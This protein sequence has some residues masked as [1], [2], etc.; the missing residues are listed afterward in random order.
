MAAGQ[1]F[2][3]FTTGEVLTAADVNGYLMQ[4]VGVFASST[5]RDAEITSPQEGQFAYLKDTNVTTYYTGSAWANLDTT[6]M[7]NPMTTTGDTIYSSS[8]STPARLGIGSTGQVLT[9]ASGVPSWATPASGGGMTLISTATPSGATGVTFSSIPASYKQLVVVWQG[10]TFS[11]GDTS[12]F[13]R[14]NGDTG[15]VYQSLGSRLNGTTP[16][17]MGPGTNDSFQQVIFYANSG[18]A[19]YNASGT[20]TV[21]RADVAQ[22]H[23]CVWQNAS[24]SSGGTQ[25]FV[26][27]Q[28]IHD[29]VNDAV[30]QIGFVRSSTQ[31]I[32]GTFYLYGVN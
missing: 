28:G 15:S 9:V 26:Q 5:E 6:G 10:V 27:G 29:N 25:Q 11:S 4:G 24:A 22:K 23:F 30:Y 32:T 20:F 13:V 19:T 12:V 1:G 8:G 7:T 18:S 17:A 14:L 31:T 3:T 21:Y 16:T 2:K